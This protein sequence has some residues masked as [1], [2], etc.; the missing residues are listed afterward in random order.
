MVMNIYAMIF[1]NIFAITMLQEKY[2]FKRI[3]ALNVK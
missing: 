1:M 3:H 2:F